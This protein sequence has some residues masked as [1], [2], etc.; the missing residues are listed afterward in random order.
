MLMR[1]T[2]SS[3]GLCF[4]FLYVLLTR[5]RVSVLIIIIFLSGIDLFFYV[6]NKVGS[7]KH[8]V[9]RG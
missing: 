3:V 4:V 7:Y 1:L 8:C 6:S 5:L 2:N 9:Q